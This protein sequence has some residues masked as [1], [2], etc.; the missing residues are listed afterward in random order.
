MTEKTA[1]VLVG[2]QGEANLGATA[3]AMKN[4]GFSDL[5]LV[6]PSAA[7][8]AE[9]RNWAVDASTL[10]E[11]ATIFESLDAALADIAFAAAFT[12]RLG[13]SRRRHLILADAAP[14]IAERAAIGGSALVFGREDAGLTNEEVARCDIVVEIPT[15][16]ELPSI[17]LAQAAMLA[18]YEM[19]KHLPPAQRKS[20]GRAE[21][22]EESFL[23]KR[24][25]AETLTRIEEM[26]AALGYEEDAERPLRAKIAERFE[27]LFGRAGLTR[28]DA[29]MF[30]G[31]ITRIVSMTRSK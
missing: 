16:A 5:R 22:L 7:I 21:A 24:D 25:I 14:L 6:A 3:R 15:S 19:S 13:R 30:E 10:L 23:P 26:L 12:R 27:K 9:A 20:G 2:P 29:A 28:R 31:L 11:N 18:C 4:F 17:N 1:I 8:D